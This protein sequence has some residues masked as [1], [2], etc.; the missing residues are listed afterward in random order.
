[1][2]DQTNE[3]VLERALRR[4]EVPEADAGAVEVLQ[5][6]RDAGPLAP[7]VVGVDE[8]YAG[9]R[10]SQIVRRQ[11]GRNGDAWSKSPKKFCKLPSRK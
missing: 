10:E 4:L 6:R 8:V 11:F 9:G 1:M 5:Q 3:D 2:P 7:R